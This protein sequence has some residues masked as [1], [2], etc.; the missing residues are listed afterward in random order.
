MGSCN[1]LNLQRCS[2]IQHRRY[3]NGKVLFTSHKPAAF[4]RFAY[5][6][7][8]K[9]ILARLKEAY[10]LQESLRQYIHT[11]DGRLVT[12]AGIQLLYYSNNGFVKRPFLLN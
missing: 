6:V 11:A 3:S 10:S 8:D 9:F 12:R 7:K 2:A 4:P 5:W 1:W